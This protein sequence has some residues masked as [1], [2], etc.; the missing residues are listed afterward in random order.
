MVN[1]LLA[2]VENL[3]GR[4]V[5]RHAH[6]NALQSEAAAWGVADDVAP[7]KPVVSLAVSSEEEEQQRKALAWA[8]STLHQAAPE[9]G[10][11]SERHL[12]SWLSSATSRRASLVASTSSTDEEKRQRAALAWSE[13][14]STAAA[15]APRATVS[16]WGTMFAHKSPTPVKA[17][18]WSEPVVALPAMHAEAT[19]WTEP[20]TTPAEPAASET[21]PQSSQGESPIAQHM[22]HEQDQ[23]SNLLGMVAGMAKDEKTKQALLRRQARVQ[24]HGESESSNQLLTDAASL[25]ASVNVAASSAT[26]ATHAASAMSEE[27][28]HEREALAWHDSSVAQSATPPAATAPRVAVSAWGSMFAHK[29]PAP[30]KVQ[31]WTE[32]VVTAPPA[33]PAEP[34]T[35]VLDQATPPSSWQA[36]SAPLPQHHQDAPAKAQ[37]WIAPIVASQPA[38]SAESVTDGAAHSSPSSWQSFSS[39]WASPAAP[40]APRQDAQGESPIA[41]HMSHEQDQVSNLLGMV[42]GM[43]KDEKT[44]QAL[45]RR[46]ARVRTHAEAQGS[47][48]LLLDAAA[49]G[50][51]VDVAESSVTATRAS[52]AARTMT[53][54]ERREREAA[55]WHDTG[56][57]QGSMLP[58]TAAHGISGTWHSGLMPA[59]AVQAPKP[60]GR[61]DS[62]IWDAIGKTASAMGVVSADA[63]TTA[64]PPKRDSL[65]AAFTRHS[66]DEDA[67]DS[68]PSA[69]PATPSRFLAAPEQSAP[70]VEH[71][72][73]AVKTGSALDSF[74]FDEPAPEE[75]R[76]ALAEKRSL[77]S[78]NLASWL[79][80][81]GAAQSQ[82]EPHAKVALKKTYENQYLADLGMESSQ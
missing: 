50:E 73:M 24:M 7:R 3:A 60:K 18:S 30:V 5:P 71:H 53:E 26:A 9:V 46:Q 4:Q 75:K 6:T 37:S 49:L 27:E 61:W 38:T 64:A 81:Q 31:S 44:K 70:A 23:V 34:V 54:E 69:A 35:S 62:S 77:M 15:P 74:T 67:D 8:S 52:A 78:D 51:S 47:N 55:G 76:V 32:P 58:A 82:P 63:T 40:E 21:Q 2:A 28:R 12:N 48:R 10:V 65:M 17:Q 66:E 68:V 29:S 33:A 59:D 42:A 19:Q 57:A 72:P 43:A 14:A 80:Y 1:G 16:S 11:A 13:A 25:G 39:R 20:A 56:V 79:G 41:Q 36:A 22:S 45:L